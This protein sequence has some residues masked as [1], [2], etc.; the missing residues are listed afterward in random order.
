MGRGWGISCRVSWASGRTWAFTLKVLGALESYK[1][2]KVGP[3]SGNHRC[4][5]DA[6]GRMVCGQQPVLGVG[7]GQLHWS[8]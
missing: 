7:V 6:A 4:L 3:D 2:S 1:Q 5:L 8:R